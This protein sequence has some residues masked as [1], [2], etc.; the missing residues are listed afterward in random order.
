MREAHT[1]GK[2]QA[3]QQP[4]NLPSFEHGEYPHKHTW[5]RS[6]QLTRLIQAQ[7]SVWHYF[8]YH[9]KFQVTVVL[10]PLEIFGP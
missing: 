7:A 1:L 9:F 2:S 3:G 10:W 5:L 8:V 6:G 4:K